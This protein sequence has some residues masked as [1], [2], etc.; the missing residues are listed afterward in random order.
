MR[1]ISKFSFIHF[2]WWR[3]PVVCPSWYVRV[4]CLLPSIV[5]IT[6][7][8]FRAALSSAFFV[9]LDH[10]AFLECSNS[11]YTVSHSPCCVCK[12]NVFYSVTV[13]VQIEALYHTEMTNVDSSSVVSFHFYLFLLPR[14]SIINIC[15]FDQ[16]DCHKF[17]HLALVRIWCLSV[18]AK[19]SALN[20]SWVWQYVLLSIIIIDS[21]G[22]LSSRSLVPF[23]IISIE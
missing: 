12:V 6:W 4:V 23:D 18:L 7:F 8:P 9:I 19:A 2:I 16:S 1:V 15:C 17:L 21:A 20:Q 10:F 22:D 3:V 5:I 11:A 14:S 13:V